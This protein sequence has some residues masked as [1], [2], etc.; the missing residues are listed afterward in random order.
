MHLHRVA[1]RRRGRAQAASRMKFPAKINFQMRKALRFAET[2]GANELSVINVIRARD[3]TLE[4]WLPSLRIQLCLK[5][6]GHKFQ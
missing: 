4:T 5:T 3:V 2:S 1:S 6:A